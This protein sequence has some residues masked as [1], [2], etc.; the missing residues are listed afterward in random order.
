MSLAGTLGSLTFGCAAASLIAACATT[1]PAPPEATAPPPKVSL[2]PAVDL[3]TAGTVRDRVR[4]IAGS[5]GSVHVLIA[6]TEL[7]KVFEVVVPRN[8][9]LQRRVIRSDV[10]PS[11]V[12]GAF[13]TQGRLHVLIDTEHMVFDSGMWQ[14]SDQT[15]WRASGL[16]IDAARFV[17]A[18]PNLV[19]VFQ[20]NGRDV[21]APGRVEIFGFGG[22]GAG[23]IWPWFTQGSRTVLVSE[24]PAGYGPWI[25]VEPE[26]KEDT[27]VADIAAD[28]QGNVHLIYTRS[29]GGLASETSHRYVRL[30]AER[31]QGRPGMASGVSDASTSSSSTFQAVE[32]QPVGKQLVV[33]GQTSSGPA[34]ISWPAGYYRSSSRLSS[35]T[36]E[37]LH[38]LTVGKARD[39]WRGK[40]FPIR[41]QMYSDHAWSG[42][43][44]VGLADVGAFWGYI[45]EALDIAS[46]GPDRAFL[47]W[48]TQQAIVGRWVERLR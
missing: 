46:A 39:Q 5:D 15:P 8:G 22:Y 42:P 43:I 32:G 28:G 29:R 24:S 16:K 21:G 18:A 20:V 2:G 6:S 26:G 47:V 27:A 10:S 35:D 17:P 7:R 41:Y 9:E 14:R 23:I 37:T 34:F 36:G 38:A 30:G 4:A 40:G 19:W 31:L 11:H 13:D 1:T 3:L 44:D 48:P 45:W 25:V 33:R 12:D